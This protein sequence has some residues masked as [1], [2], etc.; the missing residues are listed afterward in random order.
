M[1]SLPLFDLH[2]DSLFE[3]EKQNKGLVSNDLHLSFSRLSEYKRFCQIMA[4]WSNNRLEDDALYDKFFVIRKLLDRQ[5]SQA[6]K[7]GIA[8]RLCRGDGELAECEDV[9]CGALFL[10]VEGGKLL[11]GKLERLEGLYNA[12]VRFLTLVW[13]KI[14]CMGGAHDT[15]E[16][17]SPFGREA[18]AE[19]F[20]LGII[21]DLSHASGL[22]TDQVIEMCGESN[23]VC[24][25]THSNSY[26]VCRHSRNLT[27]ERFR[28]ICE[29]GGV[30]GISLA[31]EHLSAD[32]S[33]G[34]D[35]IIGHIEHYLEIGG[36]NNLCLGCDLDGVT[37]LPDGIAGVSDLEKI[38]DRLGQINYSDDQILKIFY[39]NGRRF[40]SENLK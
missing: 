32:D 30:V 5:L 10:A 19:C 4:V 13:D 27:D 26:H 17:L 28:R 1:S 38:A 34:I 11:G 23:R 2:C 22:M 15:D 21:P 29:M 8:V 33:C 25:A 20:R 9:G 7:A 16:G 37:R 18:V 6:E 24:I 40:I 31:R 12:D 35:D 14:C 3:A 36:E 39:G